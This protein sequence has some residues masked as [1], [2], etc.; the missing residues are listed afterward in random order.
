MLLAGLSRAEQVVDVTRGI[1]Y[2]ENTVSSDPSGSMGA[3]S[4][5]SVIPFDTYQFYSMSL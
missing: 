5:G 1:S 2:S 3:T 4:E